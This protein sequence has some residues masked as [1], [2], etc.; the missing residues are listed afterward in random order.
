MG[1]LLVRK[2]FFFIF[3]IFKKFFFLSVDDELASEIHALASSAKPL[4][5]WWARDTIQTCREAW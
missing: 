2:F 3:E 4:A 5:G 1:S